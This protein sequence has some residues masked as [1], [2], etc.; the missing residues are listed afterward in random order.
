MRRPTSAA[1]SVYLIAAPVLGKGRLLQVV[2][3]FSPSLPCP[4]ALQ[5]G[6]A[7]FLYTYIMIVALTTTN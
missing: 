1:R 7:A 2:N 6:L 5:S 3:R 4:F